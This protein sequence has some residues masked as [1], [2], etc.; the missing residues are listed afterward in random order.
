MSRTGLDS[1]DFYVAQRQ[2]R[3]LGHVAR[4]DF[5]RLPRRMLSAWT[6]HKRPV[7]APQL[8][9]GRSMVRAMDIFDLD[10]SR[11]H[12]LA[13]DRAAWRA[14]LYEGRAPTQFRKPPPA[15]VPMPINH[16]LV[17][18]RRT[19]AV[20]TNAAIDATLAALRDLSLED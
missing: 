6:P 9:Y 12:E 10:S 1:A 5:D 20:A 4:M 19:A 14:M 13:A 17:R 18:P 8:T 16:F 15:P 7:G 11:W 3:S 2:L